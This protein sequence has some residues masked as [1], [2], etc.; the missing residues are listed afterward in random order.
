MTPEQTQEILALRVQNLTPKEIA[1]KLG[2]RPAEVTAIIRSDS[3]QS[4]QDR[5]DRGEMAPI[6]ECLVSASFPD[7]RFLA[8]GQ[9]RPE[10][11]DSIDEIE[12][13]TIVV[14]SRKSR[15]GKLIVCTYLVDYYC[16]GIKNV[17]GPRQILESEY[18]KFKE[19][20]FQVFDNHSKTI[21]IEQAQ[22]IVLS[23]L[24]YANSLEL[25]PHPDFTEAAKSHLGL[26]DEKLSIWCGDSDGKPLFIAGPN[27]FPAKTMG[28]LDRSVGKANYNFI[29]PIGTR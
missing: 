16:L 5:L 1:R 13:L 23:S 28:I 6:Y 4:A 20:C 7:D 21:T 10:Q 9:Q 14:V 18:P 11:S 12:G 29:S 26:W 24:A 22:A 19:K 3:E 25:S 17:I 2:L 27:D 8:V 15:P